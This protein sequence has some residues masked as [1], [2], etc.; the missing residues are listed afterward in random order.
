M[1]YEAAKAYFQDLLET[2][3]LHAAASGKGQNH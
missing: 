3:R 1:D 2:E